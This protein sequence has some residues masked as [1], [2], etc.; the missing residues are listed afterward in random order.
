MTLEELQ[1]K[2]PGYVVKRWQTPRGRHIRM[3]VVK[4]ARYSECEICREC[5]VNVVKTE[6]SSATT[7]F[8]YCFKCALEVINE[9]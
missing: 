4:A 1:T 9:G 5:N 3:R 8:T 6:T 2:Y 7:L